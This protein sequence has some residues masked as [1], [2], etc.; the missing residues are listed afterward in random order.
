VAGFCA[1]TL[2]LEHL[3]VRGSVSIGERQRAEA[4]LLRASSAFLYRTR[5]IWLLAEGYS[6]DHLDQCSGKRTRPGQAWAGP[7]SRLGRR[8]PIHHLRQR[9]IRETH[10][11]M[12]SDRLGRR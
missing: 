4:Q 2:N 8:D 5:I 12:I 11:E 7:W 10:A 6:A 9:S 1:P 3:S